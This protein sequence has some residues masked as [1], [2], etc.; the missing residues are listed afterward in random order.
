MP[1]CLRRPSRRRVNRA[2]AAAT[3]AVLAVL[4]CPATQAADPGLER[5]RYLVTTILACGNCH[6]PKAADGSPVPGQELAGG[7]V[8]LDLPPF[9]GGASNITPDRE[10]GIGTWSRAEI[11]AAITTGQRPAHGRLAGVP[12][13]LPMWVNFYKA[14]TP[15]DLE[16]V[17]TYLQSV[18]AVRN[19]IAPPVYRARPPHDPYP[20]AERGFTPADLANPVRRGAYL[21]TVGHCMECHTPVVAGKAQYET[22]LGVGGRAFT[23]AMVKGLPATWTGSVARNITA[24][25]DA[26]LGRWTDA[27]IRRAITRASAATA[28]RCRHRC[29]TPG[30]QDSP[31]PTSTRWSRGCAPSR[32]GPSAALARP[33]AG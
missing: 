28:A 29:P 31:K 20:D 13:G 19:A 30:T 26:G 17:A 4:A 15:D 5:G 22:A 2:V 16:A 7:G 6:T 14:L 3:V 25:P 9:A 10:T 18:P 12:L 27:D 8:T 1:R 24:H 11:K 23:P 33:R 32:P 21:A